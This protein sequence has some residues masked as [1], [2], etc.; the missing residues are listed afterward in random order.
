MH[1]VTR[2]VAYVPTEERRVIN[3]TA[4]ALT[5]RTGRDS[6]AFALMDSAYKGR[7]MVQ[8]GWGDLGADRDAQIA[9]VRWGLSRRDTPAVAA[10]QKAV[11]SE[12]AADMIETL[13]GP[14]P[15]RETRTLRARVLAVRQALDE[16]KPDLTVTGLAV[17]QMASTTRGGIPLMQ[18]THPLTV[19]HEAGQEVWMERAMQASAYRR[20]GDEAR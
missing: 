15:D 8:E 2:E 3:T 12:M 9:G 16:P 6:A 1:Q 18:P 17:A 11:Q 7:G 4:L 14:S 13:S 10:F 5:E 20:K 19:L